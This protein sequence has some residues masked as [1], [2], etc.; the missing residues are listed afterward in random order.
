MIQSNMT[1][2]VFNTSTA[3]KMYTPPEGWGVTADR[4]GQDHAAAAGILH[5]T[6][7]YGV[8]VVK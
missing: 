8:F 2:T 3:N 4:P 5:R 1:W 6:S 7:H